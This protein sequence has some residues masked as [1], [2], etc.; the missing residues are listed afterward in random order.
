M[1][2]RIKKKKNKNAGHYSHIMEQ[3]LASLQLQR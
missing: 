2:S 3:Y 1:K